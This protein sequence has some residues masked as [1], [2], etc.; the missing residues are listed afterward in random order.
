MSV[1]RKQNEI[2]VYVSE[3]DK[4]MIVITEIEGHFN[5]R[6]GVYEDS[7]IGIDVNHIDA[8]IE[9]LTQCKKQILEQG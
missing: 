2:D 4:K 7:L 9:A 6:E 5:E 8:V 1:V 3:Q